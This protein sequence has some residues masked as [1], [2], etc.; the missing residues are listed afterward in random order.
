MHTTPYQ[1]GTKR[2]YFYLRIEHQQRSPRQRYKKPFGKQ[3]E[4]EPF[5]NSTY[6]K[7]HSY[8]NLPPFQNFSCLSPFTH[9]AFTYLPR[10]CWRERWK[11][12]RVTN[13]RRDE[14]NNPWM[15]GTVIHIIACLLFGGAWLI[16]TACP[17]NDPK[18][19][20]QERKKVT[21]Q[22]TLLPVNPTKK[23]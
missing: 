7:E 6:Q 2:R 19:V 23:K 13:L 15:K 9:Y 16:E 4:E 3:N 18:K 20:P 17:R 22:T 12:T 14:R 5:R 11:Y 1:Y 21:H 10:T 8:Y